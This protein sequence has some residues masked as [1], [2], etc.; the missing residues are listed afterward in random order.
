MTGRNSIIS[1]KT[2][3][4]V[5]IFESRE[6]ITP[7]VELLLKL[8]DGAPDTVGFILESGSVY[9]RIFDLKDDLRR[10]LIEVVSEAGD[11]LRKRNELF[12]E[13]EVGLAEQCSSE[14]GSFGFHGKSFLII[15]MESLTSPVASVEGAAK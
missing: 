7:M 11:R 3:G 14:G 1:V 12:A 8:F 15:P 9:W 6:P 5:S 2:D 13:R 10:Y 4:R